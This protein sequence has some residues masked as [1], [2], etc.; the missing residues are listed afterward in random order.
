MESMSEIEGLARRIR[1]EPDAAAD[2]RILAAAEGILE[3]SQTR[4]SVAAGTHIW[5]I[6][7]KSRIA[8]A[9]IATVIVIIA[10]A[11]L[12]HPRGQFNV[13]AAAFADVLEQIEK[14]KTI[15]WKTT[16]YSKVTSKDGK[17]RWIETE[18]REF[19]YKAPGLYRD[20]TLDENM[21]V[22]YVTITD[23]VH[24]KG[25]SLNPA[26]EEATVRELAAIEQDARGPFVWVSEQMKE[27]DLEWVGKERTAGGEV[28]VFRAAFRDEANNKDWSYDLWIDA[29]S[30]QLVAVQVPG[31]DIYNPEEDPARNNRPERGW[32]ISKPMCSVHYDIN[33]DASL[34]EW[35]FSLEP[36]EGYR[37]ESDRRAEVTEKEM[38]EFLGI[39]AEYYDKTFPG[40]VFPFPVTSDRLNEIEEKAENER[41]P[42]EQKLVETTNHYKMGGLNMLAIAHFVK[43]H[44]VKD[45]FRY[46]GKGVSLGDKDRIV[47]WYKLKGSNSYRAVYGDLSVRDVG[48]EDLPLRVEP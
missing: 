23:N 21:E 1:I 48:P 18:T 17:R 32:S 28:N 26:K 44:T 46:L 36:P 34:D 5:R 33:L 3:K 13:T 35:L 7:M 16:F 12:N 6:I 47:C 15:T 24:L 25:L 29:K 2:A 31:A 43:D 40:H 39:L 45:S 19:A 14:A 22:K 38:V 41:T 37:V 20:V 30:K 10:A 8:K 9:A 11:V 42:A 27:Q 4:E